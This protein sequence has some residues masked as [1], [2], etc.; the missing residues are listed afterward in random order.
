M[1]GLDG[2]AMILVQK[3]SPE[4][5]LLFYPGSIAKANFY[6]VCYFGK[7]PENN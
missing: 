7:V 5:T 4:D 3:R 2:K 6:Q 1:V